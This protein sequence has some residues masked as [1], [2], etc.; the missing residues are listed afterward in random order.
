M[1]IDYLAELTRQAQGFVLGHAPG[2]NPLTHSFTLSPPAGL[3][4][5]GLVDM[6]GSMSSLPRPR[7]ALTVADTVREPVTTLLREL[8][9]D[10]PLVGKW[11]RVPTPDLSNPLAEDPIGGMPVAAQLQQI[12][13]LISGLSTTLST[14][15][16]P[17]SL[18]TSDPGSAATPGVPALLGRIKGVVN[19]TVKELRDVL[20]SL[21]PIRVD[22]NL[23]IRVVDDADPSSTAQTS[24]VE[25]A[26]G[27]SNT[28]QPLSAYPAA[29][30]ALADAAPLAF[31]LR[32]PP[33][34]SELRAALPEV[35]KLSVY[36]SID[37]TVVPPAVPGLPAPA[38]LTT[39][40]DLPPLPL[41]LPTLPIPTLVVLCEHENFLG[42][43]LVVVPS[44]SPLGLALSAGGVP[45]S[46][47][48]SLANQAIRAVQGVLAAAGGALQ[49]ADFLD[50]AALGAPG[51]ASPAIARTLPAATA[52]AALTN[53]AAAPGQIIIVAASALPTLD[54]PNLVFDPGGL[55]GIGRAT[56][57]RMTS[58]LIVVGRP[59]TTVAFGQQGGWP[60]Y[61]GLTPLI[62][63]LPAGQLACAVSSL[64]PPGATIN[65]QP[66]D[67][68]SRTTTVFGGAITSFSPKQNQD[69]ISSVA[70][71]RPA[72]GLIP[73]I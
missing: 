59:G 67:P 54:A 63:T 47:A 12:S 1:A 18:M 40:I 20:R 11:V 7:F 68:R 27:S 13:G 61:E 38:P 30:M 26:F 41:V 19:E 17:A 21:D 46:T 33:L 23:R 70:I 36:V 56:A 52:A 62:I 69:Q 14:S 50:S 31:S 22:V 29:G 73:A 43:K 10:L 55:F 53:L 42:R 3:V 34:F 2:A 5:P 57:N 65:I 9:I 60:L 45:V 39:T 58:S 35:V 25:I 6:S 66:S 51:L 71:T 72:G 32:L 15:L 64:V 4:Q 44:D 49:F 28:W 8:Q 37:L 16:P 24:A 48:L